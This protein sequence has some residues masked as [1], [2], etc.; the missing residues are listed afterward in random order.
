[1]KF[2]QRRCQVLERTSLNENKDLTRK[3]I[4]GHEKNDGNKQR[5]SFNSKSQPKTSLSTTIQGGRC[6]WCQGQHPVHT[7][8]EFLRLPAEDGLQ[9]VW[10]R[11]LCINC[12]RNDHLV[13]ECKAVSCRKC[14]ERHNTSY[15]P[16]GGGTSSTTNSTRKAMG[17]SEESSGPASRAIRSDQEAKVGDSTSGESV[18]YIK[19]DRK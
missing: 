9:Q 14:G 4:D 19:R 8:N 3:R 5:S 11:K 16:I 12:L 2:L 18:P 10:R 17:N 7:C 1:M 15:H 6:Y 13:K